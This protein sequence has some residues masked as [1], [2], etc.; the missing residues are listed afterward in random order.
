MLEG[1]DPD[2]R[3]DIYSLACVIYEML[4]GRHP[5][6]DHTAVEA[7]TEKRSPALLESLS[8]SQ[9]AALAR[10][11]A[12]D[13][14]QRTASV[15]ALLA[16]LSP[17]APGAYGGADDGAKASRNRMLLI[18]GG[19]LAVIVAAIGLFV[20]WPHLF[21]S[22]SVRE[23]AVAVKAQTAVSQ[24]MVRIEASRRKVD[25][26]V[27]DARS[28]VDRLTDRI[29]LARNNG[30]QET[31]RKQLAEAQ[32][33]AETA[34][35]VNEI[36]EK[37]IF[38]VENLAALREKQRSGED[39]LQAGR[40]DEAAQALAEA[41]RSGDNVIAAADALPAAVTDQ[42]E[43]AALMER[44]RTTI[45][46]SHGDPDAALA[47]ARATATQ[48]AQALSGG[49]AVGA[50]KLFATATANVNQ[51][52][53][54]FLDRVIAALGAIAQKKMADNDLDVAQEAI[55][56]AEALQKLKVEFH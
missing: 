46:A 9:N 42:R 29:N 22:A 43:L 36:A 41:S 13:R 2:A 6:S 50:R 11:L 17:A 35:T 24:L 34:Q 51:G 1:R 20:A 15:E 25:D 40:F 19:V 16:G 45:E 39:A 23:K 38:S 56:Q 32:A 7:R 18:A 28:L 44:A 33:A 12:F 53:Q 52:V 30:E 54:A 47:N 27:R 10:A 55:S 26:R 4:S 3:D 37:G 49:D 8:R 5:F 14:E 48:A 31:L 21:P